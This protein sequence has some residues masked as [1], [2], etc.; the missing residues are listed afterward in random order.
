VTLRIFSTRG[1]RAV[2]VF[3]S[4]LFLLV[5]GA[6]RRAAQDSAHRVMERVRQ[7]QE[8]LPAWRAG[9]LI[10]IDLP[11]MKVKGKR[12]GLRHTP[13]DRFDF[14]A[15]GF[16]LLP[17]KALMWTADS[18]FAG[19]S[20]PRIVPARPGDPKGS[21]RMGGIFREEGLLARMEYRVDT[22]RWLVTQVNTWHDTL[23][24]VRLENDFIRVGRHWLPS[25]VRV[26]M[27]LTPEL[28]RFYE[29]LRATMRQRK[30]PRDGRGTVRIV[31]DGHRLG[32]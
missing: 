28:Q 13:P 2:L 1:I 12:V 19:L 29:R 32:N 22:L 11:G 9:M 27:R 5:A 7:A 21:V 31:L 23:Q 30:T 25:A 3:T 6:P 18:L 15:K 14:D 10:D 8:G 20:E 16:A 24:A 26:D 17:R 4:V